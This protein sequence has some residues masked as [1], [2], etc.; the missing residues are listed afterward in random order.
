MLADELDV[1]CMQAD[2]ALVKAAG[3]G[4]GVSRSTGDPPAFRS[5]GFGWVQQMRP[6]EAELYI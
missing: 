3:V 5:Q 1:A 4:G 2:V 6:F